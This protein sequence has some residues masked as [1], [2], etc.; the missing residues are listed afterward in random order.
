[1]ILFAGMFLLDIANGGNRPSAGNGCNQPNGGKVSGVVSFQG[2]NCQPGQPDFNIPPCSG[3]YPNYKIE[4]YREDGTNLALTAMTDPKGNYGIELPTG[5][6]VIY[7]QNGPME[8]NREKHAF[9]IE[10]GKTSNLD[11]KVS[12]GIQ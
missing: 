5:K 3:P 2:L 4:V 12:T 11:L 8:K 6:Y 1:M 10:K 7:T 9:A